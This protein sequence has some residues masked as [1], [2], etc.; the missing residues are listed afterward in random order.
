MLSWNHDTVFFAALTLTAALWMVLHLALSWRAARTP[1][2]PVWL[3]ASAWLPP[4]TLVAGFWSGARG[5]SIAW[6]VVMAV[7]LVLR[8]QV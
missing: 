7:Y 2:L 3:R 8:Q 6:L 1:S 4:L 5:L